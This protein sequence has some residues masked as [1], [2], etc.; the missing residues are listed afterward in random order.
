MTALMTTDPWINGN[1]RELQRNKE[2]LRT[3]MQATTTH[4]YLIPTS[5]NIALKQQ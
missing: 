2:R 3:N 4:H 1:F 5:T